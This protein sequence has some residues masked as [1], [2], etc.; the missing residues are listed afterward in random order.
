MI[1][2]LC[3]RGASVREH[4]DHGLEHQGEIS[5]TEEHP[6]KGVGPHQSP[7]RPQGPGVGPGAM[8]GRQP[9]GVG[10]DQSLQVWT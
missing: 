10:G 4:G 7:R 3:S 1:P 6:R 9:A 2:R 5:G 8:P